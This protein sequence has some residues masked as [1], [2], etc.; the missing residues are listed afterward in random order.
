[1]LRE[2]AGNSCAVLV[3]SSGEVYGA[4]PAEKLPI[5]EGF[6]LAPQNPYATTKA[7]ADLIAQQYRESFGLDIVVARPFNHLGPGQSDLFVGSA[8]ARQIA[9]IRCGR[10]SSKIQVGNLDPERDF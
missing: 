8:F 6:A 7:C 9:E 1:K 5:D 4:V 10:R 2:E 3:V